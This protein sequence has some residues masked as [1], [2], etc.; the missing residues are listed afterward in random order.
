MVHPDLMH[1]YFPTHSSIGSSEPRSL[2][3]INRHDDFEHWRPIPTVAGRVAIIALQEIHFSNDVRLFVQ[4]G[5]SSPVSLL[6]ASDA[7][8]GS[9]PSRQPLGVGKTEESH[10]ISGDNR[11][12]PR[13]IEFQVHGVDA[14]GAVVVQRR[15]PRQITTYLFPHSFCPTASAAMSIQDH[16]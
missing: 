16:A 10:G 2:R 9:P 12:G 15:F 7:V 13:E 14:G 4:S 5:H 3:K 8:D 6:A 1:G 11:I